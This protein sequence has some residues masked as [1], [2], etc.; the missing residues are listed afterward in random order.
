MITVVLELVAF[1]LF[2]AGMVTLYI[3]TRRSEADYTYD[4]PGLTDDEANATRFGIAAS[5]SQ[6][7]NGGL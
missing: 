4:G 2:I 3:W 7:L 5:S 1:A 6:A